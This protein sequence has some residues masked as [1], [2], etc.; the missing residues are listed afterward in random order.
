M[1]EPITTA[2]A[3]PTTAAASGTATAAGAEVATGVPEPRGTDG[4]AGYPTTP[5]LRTGMAAEG[6]SGPTGNNDSSPESRLS[7]LEPPPWLL[8]AATAPPPPAPAPASE[9]LAR[10]ARA[11]LPPSGASASRRRFTPAVAGA[12]AEPPRGASGS[13]GKACPLSASC[14]GKSAGACPVVVST[15]VMARRGSFARVSGADREVTAEWTTAERF[16]A[17]FALGSAPL[18]LGP[19]VEAACIPSAS[20]APMLGAIGVVSGADSTSNVRLQMRAA[21]SRRFEGASS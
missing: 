20:A 9:S 21:A 5:L 8:G 17:S 4:D 16:T 14:T 13:T 12:T 2:I 19:T 11:A 15:S 6:R 18:F 10:R 7:R 1:P 3:V